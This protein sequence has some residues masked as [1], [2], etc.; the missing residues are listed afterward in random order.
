MEDIADLHYSGARIIRSFQPSHDTEVNNLTLRLSI[1]LISDFRTRPT[2]VDRRC[3]GPAGD[4]EAAA[5]A[6]PARAPPDAVPPFAAAC[7]VEVPLPVQA[8]TAAAS[9]AQAAR[10]QNARIALISTLCLWC[11]MHC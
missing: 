1:I 11:G 10:A 6:P 5:E 9:A 7:T 2:F 3:L 8:V 4:G